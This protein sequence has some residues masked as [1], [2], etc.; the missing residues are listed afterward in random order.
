M[1]DFA[2]SLDNPNSCAEDL[3]EGD[4]VNFA[5]DEAIKNNIIVIIIYEVTL[6]LYIFIFI[7]FIYH[8]MR[9]ILMSKMGGVI[10]S[11]YWWIKK[12]ILLQELLKCISL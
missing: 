12:E 9:N 2:F 4:S 7:R 1:I 11:P 6:I 3:L 10:M 5:K 8:S